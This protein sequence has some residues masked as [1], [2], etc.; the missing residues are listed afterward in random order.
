MDTV[1]QHW[2][3][4][5]AWLAEFPLNTALFLNAFE[6]LLWLINSI[7]EWFLFFLSQPNQIF[8]HH[9]RQEHIWTAKGNGNQ[10]VAIC[11]IINS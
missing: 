3:F 7:F 10:F 11:G 5:L 8:I 4:G 6:I 1:R 9:Q 2:F